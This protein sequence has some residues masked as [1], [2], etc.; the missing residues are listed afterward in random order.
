MVTVEPEPSALNSRLLTLY[1]T[2]DVLLGN[3]PIIVFHGPSTTTNSTHNTSRIQAHIFSIAGYQSF[4]RLTISPTSPLYSAVHHLPTEDQGDEICRGL[5][6]SLFKYF[7]ETPKPV[8]ACL[9]DTVTNVQTEGPTPSLFGAAHAARLASQME[10]VENSA[11]IISHLLTALAAKS[12]S[13]TDIDLILPPSSISRTPRPEALADVDDKL[14]YVDSISLV[15]YGKFTEV[16]EL[17]GSPSFLPTSRLRRAPSKPSS[18]NRSRMISDDQIFALK[19]DLLELLHTERSYV[20]KLYELANSVAPQWT[21][22]VTGISAETQ[23]ITS[24]LFPPSLFQILE[25]NKHFLDRLEQLVEY[26][27]TITTTTTTERD[28]TGTNAFAKL[29]L[30]I[31]PEFQQPYVEY[32]K[33]S[34]K[35]FHILTDLSRDNVSPFA[36]QL[37][38]TGEQRLRSWLIEPV[39]RLPRYVLFIEN[40]TKKLPADHM[41]IPKL[42]RAKDLIGNILDAQEA[43][44]DHGVKALRILQ[45]LVSNW[46]ASL[47]PGRLVT[48][49]DV[50]ELMPPYSYNPRVKDEL[51]SLILLFPDHVL[52][53]KKIMS[54]A[55]SARGLMVEVDRPSTGN[56]QQP[57]LSLTHTFRLHETRFT[58]SHDGNLIYLA[59]VEKPCAGQYIETNIK[60]FSTTTNIYALLG[61][62]E[63]KAAR[64]NEEVARARIEHRFPEKLREDDR[65]GLRMINPIEKSNLGIVS[66]IFEE[67]IDAQTGLKRERYGRIRVV[68]QAEEQNHTWQDDLEDIEIAAR[69]TMVGLSKYRLEFKGFS[70][71]FSLDN[72]HAGDLLNVFLRQCKW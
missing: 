50:A 15:D 11:Q 26:Y 22:N 35:F 46:P 44:L 43:D 27:T 16:V 61:S 30:E 45:A 62:Y 69:I 18:W 12:L 25:I 54:N 6:I 39:Q 29:L 34:N 24:C 47:D 10:R 5:A 67:D 68:V 57:A 52:I 9:R 13:W 21:Q 66:A 65:W 2:K 70:Q 72:I 58:E 28:I 37:Q 48:A 51:Q 19:Q 20:S 40:I 42:L 64:W 59:S 8:Q 56:K 38:Q 49:A 55:L 41:A 36:R 7:N 1:S 53:V 17:F 60:Y 31:L 23:R 33:A 63:G 4:P 32:I 3:L 14:A 71:N